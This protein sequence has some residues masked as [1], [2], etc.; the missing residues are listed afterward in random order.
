MFIPEGITSKYSFLMTLILNVTDNPKL[1]T[2]NI[3]VCSLQIKVLYL[4]YQYIWQRALS[5]YIVLS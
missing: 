4:G 5:S 1:N 2:F 3:A